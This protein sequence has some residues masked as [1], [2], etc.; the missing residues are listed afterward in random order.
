MKLK[1]GL[2]YLSQ[3]QEIVKI[4]KEV[5]NQGLYCFQG[6]NGIWYS[7]WGGCSLGT[8]GDNLAQRWVGDIF[9]QKIRFFIHN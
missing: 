3:N 2:M 5:P 6:S 9:Q 4:M 8:F 7:V 1:V